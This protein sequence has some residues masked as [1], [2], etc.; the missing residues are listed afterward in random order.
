MATTTDLHA[1]LLLTMIRSKI[2]LH[3]ALGWKLTDRSRVA[4][5]AVDL[6]VDP[7]LES[8]LILRFREGW[9]ASATMM[10]PHQNRSLP[11]R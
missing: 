2:I 3:M 4:A 5:L 11:C 10:P 7:Q 8:E 1:I 6:T 9:F